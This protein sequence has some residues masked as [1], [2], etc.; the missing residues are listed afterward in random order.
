MKNSETLMLQE[1]WRRAYRAGEDGLE[2]GFQTKAGAVRARMQLYNS[3]KLQ[4]SG[5]DMEDMELVYAAEQLEIVWTGEKSIKLQRR[6]KSDMMQSIA[7]V[8]GKKASDFVDP[9]AA[10]SAERMMQ[11]LDEIKAGTDSIIEHKHNDFY[12]KRS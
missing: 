8:L 5:K 10:A 1:V 2:I 6:D 9:D 4:K 11:Q 7:A 12:G 3:V